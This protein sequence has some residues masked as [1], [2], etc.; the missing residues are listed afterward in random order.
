MTNLYRVYI[1]DSGNVDPKASNDP[2]LRYGSVTGV[3]LSA[4]Y[5]DK[6]FNSSFETISKRH[7]GTREDG[8]P[9]NLHRR[10]LGTPPAEG[11]FSVLSDQER[12]ARWDTTALRMFKLA[13]FTVITV[14]VDKVAWYYHYPE[15]N[16][17][18]YDILVRGL[19]ERLFYFLRYRGQA[20]VFIETKNG[21][22]DLRVKHRF[23]EGLEKGYDHIPAHRLQRV[24]TSREIRVLTKGDTRPGMQ[25]ADLIAGPALQHCRFLATGRHPIESPFIRQVAAILEESKF[26]REEGKG[27]EGCGRVWRPNR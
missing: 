25:L 1:D 26:Y 13:E 20:E 19:L 17:D 3:V 10:L 7:F 12:R 9:H 6:T 21:P 23:R 24:F 16:G 18:F 27:V 4:A 15:W 22:R 8:R 5:L 14:A 2:A 11:P